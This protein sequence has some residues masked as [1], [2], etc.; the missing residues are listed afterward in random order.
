LILFNQSS[1]SR[2][3]FTLSNLESVLRE[4]LLQLLASVFVLLD[5]AG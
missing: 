3:V 2:A 5:E 1:F 4:L